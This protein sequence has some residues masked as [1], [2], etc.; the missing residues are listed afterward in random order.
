M[1]VV[2][3]ATVQVPDFALDSVEP[4]EV[5]LGYCSS[6]SGCVWMASHLSG[7]LTATQNGVICKLVEGAHNLT[8]D[9]NDEDI[10]EH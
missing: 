5:L 1:L 9:V 4:H 6:I 7:V 2:G 3:V 8:V 10:K